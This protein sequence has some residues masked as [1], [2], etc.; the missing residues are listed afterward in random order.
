MSVCLHIVCGFFRS[1]M[2]DLT[3]FDRD[4][5]PCKT[6]NIHYPALNIKGLPASKSRMQTDHL[7][8]ETFL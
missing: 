4:H 6:E 5:M 7:Y 3:S 1:T 8:I 2:S